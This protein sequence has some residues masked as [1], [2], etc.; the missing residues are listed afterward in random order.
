MNEALG[1]LERPGTGDERTLASDVVLR[2]AVERWLQ[3]AIEACI[4][5]ADHVVA[6]EGWAPPASARAAFAAL[7][8]HGRLP[9][10]L[11]DRLG[12]AA[13][14]RNVLVH[15]YVAVDL[16]RLAATVREDLGDLRAF[17]AHAAQW[18]A[19]EG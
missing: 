8:A 14:L 2:A 13:G 3:I 18:M 9:L 17:A 5:I 19:V 10:D 12:D 4:D 6:S 7:A 1:E 16:A 11:A 15:D